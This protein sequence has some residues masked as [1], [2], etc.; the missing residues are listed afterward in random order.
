MQKFYW[1]FQLIILQIFFVRFGTANS[2]PKIYL[3]RHAAVN[4]PRPGWGSAKKSKEYKKVYNISGVE[5]FDPD[6]ALGKIENHASLDTVFCSSQ[7]RAQETAL[8]LFD[9]NIALV[10]D[11]VL[12]EF[13]Y[14]VIQIPILQLPVKSWLA[15]SRIIWMAGINRGKNSDYKNRLIELNDFS[16]ELIKFAQ[17]NQHAAVVAHG[18]V[19]RKLV[20]LL[21]NKGWQFC[22]NGKDGHRNLSVNCM[23]YHR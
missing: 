19:N 12:I 10:T 1:I 16:D 13:D 23:E 4:L 3:I 5:T 20:K 2:I 7:L 22:E 15:V 21:K 18:F 11:S 9:E 6:V 17:Q 8:I 14:P